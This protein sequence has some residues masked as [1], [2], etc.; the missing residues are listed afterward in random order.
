[1]S[2]IWIS[3][4]SAHTIL[5]HDLGMSR[6]AIKF[7]INVCGVTSGLLGKQSKLKVKR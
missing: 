3:D 5:T 1:M 6:V 7:V 2:E 4:G